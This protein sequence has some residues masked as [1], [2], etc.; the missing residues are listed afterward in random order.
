MEAN[1]IEV[2]RWYKAKNKFRPARY[3]LYI[4]VDRKR[5]QIDGDEVKIGS[6]RPMKTMESFLKWCGGKAKVDSEG[7]L[8]G[9]GQGDD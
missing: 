2:G 7:Y 9:Q 4:S 6:K 8:V 1:E 5:V 3:V